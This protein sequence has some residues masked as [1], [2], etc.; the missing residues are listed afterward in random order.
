MTAQ[1]ANG[2]D[3]LLLGVFRNSSSATTSCRSFSALFDFTVLMQP[4]L[5]RVVN[6]SLPQSLQPNM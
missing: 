6:L 1:T 2:S 4:E 3:D 5:E